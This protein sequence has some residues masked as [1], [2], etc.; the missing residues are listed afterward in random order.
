[1]REDHSFNRLKTEARVNHRPQRHG[2]ADGR[3]VRV[4]LALREPAGA[5]NAWL[6][7][8][9]RCR[10]RD[11]AKRLFAWRRRWWWGWG[12]GWRR[13]LRLPRA[14]IAKPVGEQEVE[15]GRELLALREAL[16]QLAVLLRQALVRP[17]LRLHHEARAQQ[18]DGQRAAQDLPLRGHGCSR[19]TLHVP[20]PRHP[21]R[22]TTS[23]HTRTAVR[24]ALLRNCTTTSSCCGSGA[25]AAGAALQWL[26]SREFQGRLPP[27]PHGPSIARTVPRGTCYEYPISRAR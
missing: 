23:R 20:G 13:Q 11:V 7:G 19:T 24:D 17:A 2:V 9:P 3:Q 22:R 14:A 10:D 27:R 16:R 4:R 21:P 6:R 15:P 5:A 8:Y 1:M 26:E 25:V 12:R 18:R